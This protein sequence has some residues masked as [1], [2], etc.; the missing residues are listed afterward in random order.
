MKP[1]INWFAAKYIRMNNLKEFL[2]AKRITIHALTTE[3]A[4][5]NVVETQ[6]SINNKRRCLKSLRREE[7]QLQRELRQLIDFP[8]TTELPI[9]LYSQHNRENYDIIEYEWYIPD[10]RKHYSTR[11]TG[12]NHGFIQG[13]LDLRPITITKEWIAVFEKDDGSS[14]FENTR[15]I[16]KD[17]FYWDLNR[18]IN[19]VLRKRAVKTWEDVRVMLASRFELPEDCP[20]SKNSD[21]TDYPIQLKTHHYS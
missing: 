13:A 18:Q 15:Q 1:R 6:A 2:N 21:D 11:S 19:L 17:D 3:I 5:P 10:F 7:A 9:L 20:L 14:V 12:P 8:K 16:L 4:H